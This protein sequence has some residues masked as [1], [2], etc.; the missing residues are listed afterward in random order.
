LLIVTPSS[1]TL[2]RQGNT[3][4]SILQGWKR[5]NP[6][7]HVQHL[8]F[9]IFFLHSTLVN[10]PWVHYLLL[11]SCYWDCKVGVTPYFEGEFKIRDNSIFN[12]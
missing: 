7:S 10:V 6:H 4:T 9:T 2:K 5:T 8:L 1:E 11:L 3:M 12:L